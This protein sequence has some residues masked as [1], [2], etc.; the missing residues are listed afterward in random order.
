M[1]H[2]FCLASPTV[3]SAVWPPSVLTIAKLNARAIWR[4][5]AIS[6]LGC[7]WIILR[8]SRGL[9]GSAINNRFKLNPCQA[10]NETL[11][12]AKIR[13]VT[14]HV[15]NQPVGGLIKSDLRQK[16]FAQQRQ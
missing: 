7:T 16:N 13:N 12:G 1:V 3:A 8:A 10:Q 6:H 2:C 11:L 4:N 5:L 14:F 9:P 15:V